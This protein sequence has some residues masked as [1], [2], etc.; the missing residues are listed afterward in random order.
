MNTE[1]PS[2]LGSVIVHAFEYGGNILSLKGLDCLSKGH[3]LYLGSGHGK[4][5]DI[6]EMDNRPF[7]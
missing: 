1:D 4:H 2:G 7:A 5:G 3:I 6:P